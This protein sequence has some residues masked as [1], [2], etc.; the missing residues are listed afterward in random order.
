MECPFCHHALGPDDIAFCPLCG[1]TLPESPAQSPGAYDWFVSWEGT[2]GAELV[3]GLAAALELR[4]IRALVPDRAAPPLE[5]KS[6]ALTLGACKRL[7]LLSPTGGVR[8]P[9]VGRELTWWVRNRGQEEI[10]TVLEPDSPPEARPQL[11]DVVSL[12]ADASA[13]LIEL[14]ST[15]RTGAHPDPVPISTGAPQA[16]PAPRI[17][18]E[19]PVTGSGAEATLEMP[20]PQVD[21]VH[22]TLTAPSCLPP[23]SY[24]ELAFW[25]H[26]EGQRDEVIR[27]AMRQLG[28][29][30]ESDLAVKSEG[31]YEMVRGAKLSVS[32]TVDGIE[33]E[34]AHK[35][36]SWKGQI[37]TASFV[38]AVPPNADLAACK[39]VASIRADGIEFARMH[40]V[41]AIR[42]AAGKLGPVASEVSRHRTAFASYATEDRAQVM[43]RVQG[44]VKIA[45][46][47]HVFLDVLSLRAGDYWAQQIESRIPSSDIFYLFWSRH[48]LA[49]KYVEQEWR[50]ALERKGLDFIDPVPLDPPEFAP[51]P[52]ELAAKHFNDPL[53]SHMK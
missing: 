3:R 8:T 41:L 9:E 53:L 31:P 44:I 23:G 19:T 43:A 22:F 7:V 25:C 50:C 26:L 39:G 12:G 13:S 37:G 16:R 33:V 29:Q 18:K 10:L 5:G 34:P 24:S 47:L 21:D 46:D 36:V 27:R 4:G 48:A 2:R 52:L 38:L 20:I 28:A 1:G 49:S 40:F 6:L 35:S 51:P 11:G 14:L 15:S 32:V 45:P 17:G 42:N 30:S